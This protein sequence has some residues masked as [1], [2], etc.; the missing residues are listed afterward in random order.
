MGNFSVRIWLQDVS[1]FLDTPQIERYYHGFDISAEQFPENPGAIQFSV[2]DLTIPFPREHRERYDL[3]HVRLLVAALEEADYKAAIAN[4][5]DILSM[6]NP[7]LCTSHCC[8]TS[9]Y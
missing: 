5:Y 2:Q 8:L 6:A 9:W 3:V 4:I 1:K 7:F